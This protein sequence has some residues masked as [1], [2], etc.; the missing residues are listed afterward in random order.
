M[1]PEAPPP[2]NK[3][4]V[5]YNL[6]QPRLVRSFPEPLCSDAF[7]G[8]LNG[9]T[10]EMIRQINMMVEKATTYLHSSVIPNFAIWLD[11]NAKIFKDPA[12][13]VTEAH[14]YARSFMFFFFFWLRD[15]L[16]KF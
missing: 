11:Q 16:F 6:L 9:E 5:F 15:R 14:K 7:S 13:L 8:W 4:A 12:L 2:D 10:P 1:P 3:R